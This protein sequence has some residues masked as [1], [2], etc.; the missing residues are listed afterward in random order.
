MMSRLY[1]FSFHI[2]II[3]S[4][5][6]HSSE[7]LNVIAKVITDYASVVFDVVKGLSKTQLMN[8]H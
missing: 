5:I 7:R 8:G 1:A 6:L 2:H 3:H 4:L